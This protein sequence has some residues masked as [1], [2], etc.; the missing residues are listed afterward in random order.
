M[1][2]RRVVTEWNFSLSRLPL[3]AP[4]GV[5]SRCPSIDAFFF[6]AETHGKVRSAMS[7]SPPWVRLLAR[8]SYTVRPFSSRG[9]SARRCVLSAVPRPA[10]NTSLPA[11]DGAIVSTAPR[12][13]LLSERRANTSK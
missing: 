8:M 13:S 12:A 6:P 10:D 9:R 7:L 11:T 2:L 5:C 3:G 1:C 4:L